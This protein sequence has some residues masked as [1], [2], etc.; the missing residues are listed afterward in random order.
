M[1]VKRGRRGEG[2]EEQREGKDDGAY[3]KVALFL[4]QYP[5]LA[6]V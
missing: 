4:T 3:M 2:G 5:P 1:V 6:F